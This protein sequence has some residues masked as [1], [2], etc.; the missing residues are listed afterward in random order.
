LAPNGRIGYLPQGFALPP[1]ATLAEV[2]GRATGDVDTLEPELVA[3]ADAL[4]QQPNNHA[5][6]Q[7]Y[8]AILHQ[9]ST[10]NPGHAAA[11]L[12]GLGLDE[13]PQEIPVGRLSGGQKTRLNLALVLLAEPH[14]LLLDE[15]TNHLDIGMLEWLEAWLTD[16]P[17]GALI[18]S[19]DRTF[20][21]RTVNRILAFN[22]HKREVREFAGNYTAYQE[23]VQQ[24]LEKQWEAFQD[25]QQEIRRVREDIARVKAQAARTE[26]EASSVRIGGE[27]MKLK[28]Y[29]DYQQ[30]IAKKVAKKAKSREQKLE[31]YLED[32]ERVERPYRSR[33]LKLD[34]AE[35]AHL[36]HSVLALHDL[37]VGYDRERPLLHHLNL[38]VSSAARIIITG[39]NGCGK[40]TLL[41]TLTGQLIPL[42]GVIEQGPSVQ[43][44]YMSQEQSTLDPSR[45]PLETLQPLFGSETET[46]TF[47]SY[48]LFTGSEPLKRNRDLSYG[49]RA[50]LELALIIANGCNVLLLDE[51]INH[52]DIPAREQFEQALHQFQGVILAVVHDRYFIERLATE[53]W[54][55]ADA[56]I[57]KELMATPE[58]GYGVGV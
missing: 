33:G 23:Q 48:F 8:D 51:P 41:R 20:L 7:R 57:H 39:P 31:R 26:R 11:I 44:G 2:I 30:S 52:L 27:K 42:A 1:L 21:D 17:G 13:M 5:L 14:L 56:G 37:S 28:G 54:W 40:T 47:L 3:L 6:Q 29:K 12:A 9:L 43:I 38:T 55:V 35:T 18:V 50:R 32:E 16:F 15:P 45:T 36:G 53:I 4:A 25:Q 49:Q 24:E 34:F 10:A 19:H 58:I 22:P 46:R